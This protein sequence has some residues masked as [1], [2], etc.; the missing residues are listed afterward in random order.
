VSSQPG[1]PPPRGPVS[2]AAGRDHG[3]V[4]RAPTPRSSAFSTPKLLL[5]AVVAAVTVFLLLIGIDLPTA[6]A[7][8]GGIGVVAQQLAHWLTPATKDAAG[9]REVAETPPEVA[10]PTGTTGDRDDQ[11]PPLP[12]AR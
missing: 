2:H 1:F 3:S 7:A 4:R 11:S 12:P 5:L 10:G 9:H 6:L 8:V